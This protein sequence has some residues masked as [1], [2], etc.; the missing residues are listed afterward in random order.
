MKEKVALE[1][2]IIKKSWGE[3]VI[4][5]GRDVG[6]KRGTT[7][8][9]LETGEEFRDPTT[10]E[11][12]GKEEVRKGVIYVT[13][14]QEK[15]ARAKIL[16]GRYSITEG[17]QLKET[18]RWRSGWKVGFDY[19]VAP[20]TAEANTFSE[21]VTVPTHINFVTGLLAFAAFGI[22]VWIVIIINN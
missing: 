20:V 10:G 1:A 21:E 6:V 9:V 8:N 14:A 18:S 16:K 7:F 5:L 15:F 2:S 4:N 12:Y 13:S 17:M 11:V 22:F 19:S 3:V